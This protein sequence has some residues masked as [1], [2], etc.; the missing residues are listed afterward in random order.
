MTHFAIAIR[1]ARLASGMT[2]EQV[3]SRVWGDGGRHVRVWERG[4]RRASPQLAGRLARA[5]GVPPWRFLQSLLED[6]QDSM[7]TRSERTMVVV[8]ITAFAMSMSD[9]EW[10]ELRRDPARMA[11]AVASWRDGNA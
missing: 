3:D 10:T 7:C 8:G 11:E 5:M 2:H 9:A 6:V 1:R 4:R